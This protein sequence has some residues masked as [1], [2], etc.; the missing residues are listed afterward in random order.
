MSRTIKLFLF[1]DFFKVLCLAFWKIEEEDLAEGNKM[2]NLGPRTK[3]E[4]DEDITCCGQIIISSY[5]QA[6]EM[7][8]FILGIYKQRE[9]LHQVNLYIKTG[10]PE[11]F[12]IQPETNSQVWGYNWGVSRSSETNWGYMRSASHAV[13]PTMADKWKVF[14]KSIKSWVMDQTVRVKCS[15]RFL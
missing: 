11:M 13:C 15:G 2:F 8:P 1:I 6:R 3:V 7:Y 5:A 9:T 10:T 4:Y 12:M 14:D